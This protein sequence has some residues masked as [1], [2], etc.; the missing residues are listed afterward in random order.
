MRPAPMAL[1]PTSLLPISS[2]VGSPT[3]VPWA[4]SCVDK[5]EASNASKVGVDACVTALLGESGAIP[6]PSATT[7][8]TGPKRP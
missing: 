4:A 2:S 5:S 1:C 8:R 3:A 7:T 6:T